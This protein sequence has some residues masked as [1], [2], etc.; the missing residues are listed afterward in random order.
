MVHNMATGTVF[1]LLP[2]GRLVVSGN[3]PRTAMFGDGIG[4]GE[5]G[6]I[7][8]EGEMES[9]LAERDAPRS[10]NRRGR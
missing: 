2:A 10:G 8:A 6:Y 4:V 5:N 3:I 7:R 9:A 1:D